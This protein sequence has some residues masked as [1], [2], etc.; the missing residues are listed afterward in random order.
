MTAEELNESLRAEIAYLS[1]SKAELIRLNAKYR[2]YAYFL[3][4]CLRNGV[5]IPYDY[6]FSAFKEVFCHGQI[7]DYEI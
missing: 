2:A 1:A 7:Q 3:R 5:Q 6:N 4:E